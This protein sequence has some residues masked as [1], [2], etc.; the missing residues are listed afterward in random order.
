VIQQATRTIG[1][2]AD[3]RG[4]GRCRSPKCGARI[5]WAELAVGGKRMCFTGDPVVLR[6]EQRASDGRL[7]EYVDF[8]DNHWATCRDTERFGRKRGARS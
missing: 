1:I 6:T 7:V 8:A 3:T 4:P 2:L 5:T